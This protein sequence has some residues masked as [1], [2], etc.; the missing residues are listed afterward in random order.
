M[1]RELA[2]RIQVAYDRCKAF[3][4]AGKQDAFFMVRG[5]AY[6]ALLELRNMC[7]EIVLAL[8]RD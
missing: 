2:D 8:N 4:E 6:M 1:S 7:P 5:D 3:P